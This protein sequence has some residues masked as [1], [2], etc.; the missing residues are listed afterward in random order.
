MPVRQLLGNL[1]SP[2]LLPGGP[3]G[4]GAGGSTTAVLPMLRQRKNSTAR[5][6][7]GM[8]WGRWFD[9]S[10][11]SA[12]CHYPA[13]RAVLE[14]ADWQWS[15]FPSGARP[16]NQFILGY[17]IFSEAAC[18]TVAGNRWQPVVIAGWPGMC[19]RGPIGSGRAAQVAPGQ[20]INR[21]WSAGAARGMLAR[22]LLG[23]PSG[24]LLLPGGPGGAGAGGLT[25]VGLPM[26]QQG[27]K[28]TAPRLL[29]LQ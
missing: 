13:A 21:S 8:L 9:S 28:S 10:T 29:G 1:D 2:M 19:R 27:K 4:A 5:G 25:A 24:P 12:R 20:N 18:M 3:S 14:L 11:L 17:K 16:I 7:P 22:Q 15:C 26:R 6:H 23:N